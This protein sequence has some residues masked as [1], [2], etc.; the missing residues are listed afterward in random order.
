MEMVKIKVIG[1]LTILAGCVFINSPVMAITKSEAKPKALSKAEISQDPKKNLEEGE[2]FLA[3]NKRKPGV[4]TL[5][6]GLQYKEIKA[7][8]GK[9]PGSQ[10]YVTVHYRGTLLNGKEFDNSEKRKAP[11]EFEVDAV[12]PGWTE[13]L[14][15]MKPGSEWVI[16]VPPQLAYGSRGIPGVIPP[17]ATLIFKVRLLS[18]GKAAEENDSEVLPDTEV[19]E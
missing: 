19:K 13:A 2:K 7:G 15:L 11:A 6:S 16:Y 8:K 14:Q 12:I 9:S 4:V 17:N 5:S 1:V 3:A 10:G 18:I